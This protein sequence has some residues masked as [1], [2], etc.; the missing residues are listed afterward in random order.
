MS[1][2][3]MRKMEAQRSEVIHSKSHSQ[4]RNR[5]GKPGLAI[6]IQSCIPITQLNCHLGKESG[7]LT[8]Q[9]HFTRFISC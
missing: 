8:R 1:V 3:Q 5:A 2:G 7:L 4:M 6:W 9:V